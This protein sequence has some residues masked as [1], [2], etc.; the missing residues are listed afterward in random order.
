MT[1]PLDQP[2]TVS[3]IMFGLPVSINGVT[4]QVDWTQ[5]DG[6]RAQDVRTW[7]TDT[8]T[9]APKMLEMDL[10]PSST[11]PHTR[12][13]VVYLIN[14]DTNRGIGLARHPETRE[15]IGTFPARVMIYQNAYWGMPEEWIDDSDDH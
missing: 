1:D 11:A 14:E 5:Q 8:P 2:F 10:P 12:R 3:P 9:E 13:T 4:V 15:L 7:L 6:Q